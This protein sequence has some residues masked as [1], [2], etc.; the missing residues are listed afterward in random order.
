MPECA[1]GG[2]AFLNKFTVSLQLPGPLA[3]ARQGLEQLSD[4]P[5][6]RRQL[7]AV[8]AKCSMSGDYM[9]MDYKD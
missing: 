3:L 2:L 9:P 1:V 7:R 8:G 6:I 4:A 5:E